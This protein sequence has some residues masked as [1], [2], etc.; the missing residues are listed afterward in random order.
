MTVRRGDRIG[1]RFEILAEAAHGGMG[2]VFRARDLRDRRD[3]ALKVLM[4]GEDEA[5]FSREA[6]LLAAVRHE[7][8][9][10]YIAHG[11]V[12]DGPRYLVMEWVEGETL[13]SR[14]SRTGIDRRETVEVGLQLARALGALHGA[15]IVHRDVKPANVML[16]AGSDRLQLVDLGI[17]RRAGAEARLTRTGTLV[18]TAGYMAPE[19][20]RGD[21]A[22]DHRADLFALGCVLY[23]CLTGEPAFRGES[24]LALRAKVLLHDPPR[25]ASLAADTPPAL[26]SLVAALLARDVAHRPTSAATVEQALQGL[27]EVPAGRP[28]PAV[29]WSGVTTVSA[30]RAPACVVLVS[31][32]ARLDA[33]ETLPG[34]AGG[35]PFDGGAAIGCA[36]A[37]AVALA[38]AWQ[39]AG[40]A[41]VACADSM[42]EAIDRCARLIGQVELAAVT[43]DAAAGGAWTD[44]GSAERLGLDERG[45]GA[46]IRIR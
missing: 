19:Q 12:P 1:G 7:H 40:V 21:A 41:A 20:A 26:D 35:A 36:P 44:A 42:G 22:I 13:A 39:S 6:A 14:L 33:G 18:G 9:V 15:G 37:E 38:A 17:A 3:V 5:R 10:R 25:V 11:S 31:F 43:S 16:A 29:G 8:V 27:G 23:E 30:A 4:R 32:A 45:A 24:P 28:R 46:P 2:T 34:T